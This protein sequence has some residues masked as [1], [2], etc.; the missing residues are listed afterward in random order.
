MSM[1]LMIIGFIASVFWGMRAFYL[2]TPKTNAKGEEYSNWKKFLIGGF[3]Q[4]FLNFTCSVSGWIAVYFLLI[5]HNGANILF[6]I[7]DL[8]L[9]LIAIYGITGNLAEILFKTS[10][11]LENWTKNNSN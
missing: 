2:F 11:F 7:S 10:K 9:F 8:I 4:F 6:E 1:C 3:Y 5:R